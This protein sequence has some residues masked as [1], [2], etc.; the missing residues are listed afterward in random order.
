MIFT[1]F[2]WLSES[3]L[4]KQQQQQQPCKPTYFDLVRNYTVLFFQ[5]CDINSNIGA[6]I[7]IALA[8]AVHRFFRSPSLSLSG[9]L[10]LHSRYTL[11]SYNYKVDVHMYLI[12]L[13]CGCVC[14]SRWWRMRCW[15][16]SP[17]LAMVA[18]LI[19][20]CGEEYERAASGR[21]GSSNTSLRIALVINTC[22]LRLYFNK[23]I[24]H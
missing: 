17:A 20:R 3:S 14:R 16:R 11:V 22:K 2:Q 7:H 13:I 12:L 21:E 1:L 9:S 19:A 6:Y 24:L 10:S 23:K 15:Y 18:M 8:L 5:L 4:S